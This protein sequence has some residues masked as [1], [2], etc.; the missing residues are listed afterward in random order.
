M[1]QEYARYFDLTGK[2]AVITGGARGIGYHIA[3]T[4]AQ[5]GAEVAIADRD[6][7]A[8]AE[9]AQTI[10]REGGAA[11][12]VVCELSDPDDIARLFGSV[13]RIFRRLDIL[14]NNA[15]KVVRSPALETPAALWKEV[16]D[17]NLTAPFLCSCE[18]MRLFDL[19]R[20]GA[21]INLASIMGVS[22]GGSYPISSYHATKG[23]IVNLT[24]AL[25]VEWA[26]KVRVNAIAPTWVRTEFTRALLDDPVRAD[27]LRVLMPAQKFAETIDVALAALYLASPAAA[28][29]TGHTLPVDG[30]FLAR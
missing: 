14:V 26:P 27:S 10:T 25:A 8:A 15:A 2:T 22:G 11:H 17:V 29:V 6:E 23:G 4:F 9:A 13:A 20:G 21:I 30:G 28:M 5:A 1:N 3:L 16:I 12:A 19:E 18:A 24:R 7:K